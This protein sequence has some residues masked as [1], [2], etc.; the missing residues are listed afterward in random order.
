MKYETFKNF[1]INAG[2]SERVF[3]EK[4]A[5]RK[6]A[7][8]DIRNFVTC[9]VATKACSEDL[10]PAMKI[11]FDSTQAKWPIDRKKT[12]ATPTK[13]TSK[14][15]VQSESVKNDF[16]VFIK[17]LTIG[18]ANNDHFDL[19]FVIADS[20]L[21]AEAMHHHCFDGFG[22]GSDRKGHVIVMKNR[23]G[24]TAFFKKF[25]CELVPEFIERL[26]QKYDLNETKAFVTC[27]GEREQV[28]ALLH[29]NGTIENNIRMNLDSK[30]ILLM[31]L[32]ASCSG[33][34]QP[35]D[36]A[37]MYNL[38]KKKMSTLEPSII[39]ALK[40]QKKSLID[41]MDAFLKALIPGVPPMKAEDRRKRTEAIVIIDYCFQNIYTAGTYAF[42]FKQSGCHP[43]SLSQFVRQC[44]TPY[45]EDMVDLIN[46]ALPELENAF[47]KS[48][49]IPEDL[50]D[51]LNIPNIYADTEKRRKDEKVAWQQRAVL[52][53]GEEFLATQLSIR[54]AGEAEAKRAAKA[55]QEKVDREAA[56][57]SQVKEIK[58]DSIKQVDAMKG[59][60]NASE[61]KN[62]GLWEENKALKSKLKV[63]EKATED[64]KK[65][66][67]HD[68]NRKITKQSRNSSSSASSSAFR[69]E[70]NV[71][72]HCTFCLG[73]CPTGKH[74][75]PTCEH[76]NTVHACKQR[77]EC[78]NLFVKHK[79]AC[80]KNHSSLL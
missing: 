8:A 48:H 68:K 69:D 50:M 70:N 9:F 60:L 74:Q 76:C 57:R 1:L 53:S 49:M 66:C 63:A 67:D 12:A 42:G 71:A 14:H 61:A 33:A 79:E 18:T 38:M 15:Q 29:Q 31:K 80:L 56:L 11:N 54:A 44:T 40:E 45:S 34:L 13:R 72:V 16:P 77:G 41:R 3:Q 36:L 2:I 64:L 4:D 37:K 26:K 51:R 39:D 75:Y 47:L 59:K 43:L 19:I 32:P 17:L 73:P 55:K 52:L 24:N 35:S 6:K 10:H 46:C 25:L 5:S 21:D 7:E 20:R 78:F 27:D 65:A 30:D 58:L 28:G 23:S 22:C 62:K